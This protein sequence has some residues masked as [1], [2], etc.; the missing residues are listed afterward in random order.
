[1]PSKK[2]AKDTAPPAELATPAP[3]PAPAPQTASASPLVE[4]LLAPEVFASDAQTI[5][6]VQGMV[7]IAF[8]SARYD[9]STTPS[10]MR[11]VV[12]SRLVM[13]PAAASS[14]AVRLF[15]FL[16]KN[17]MGAVPKDAKKVQ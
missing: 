4:N 12:V 17:G 7:S 16:E 1:M 2:K 6:L 10:V 11:K 5:S 3:E 14:M 8:T 9:Y 13:P 15:A